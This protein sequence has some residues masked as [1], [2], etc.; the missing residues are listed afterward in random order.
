MF[1][2]KLFN[3]GIE[4]FLSANFQHSLLHTE[5]LGWMGLSLCLLVCDVF[6]CTHPGKGPSNS[7]G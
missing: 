4:S 7:S 5:G 2:L 3:A 6:V 1:H